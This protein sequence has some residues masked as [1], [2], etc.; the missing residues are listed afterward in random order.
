MSAGSRV[1]NAFEMAVREE[2]KRQKRLALKAGRADAG[3]DA[4]RA[5]GAQCV[6]RRHGEGGS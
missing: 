6:C 1:D 2:K 5:A 4:V 3:A